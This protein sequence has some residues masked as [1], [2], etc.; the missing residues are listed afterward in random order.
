MRK[1]IAILL[2]CLVPSL[3][4][5]QTAAPSVTITPPRIEATGITLKHVAIVVGAVVLG[6]VVGEAIIGDAL[7]TMIGMAAGY[8]IG[9]Q[10]A[11]EFEDEML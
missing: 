3:S 11:E 7:G 2:L 1:L 9:S 8:L 6:A 5:A 10:V 4:F